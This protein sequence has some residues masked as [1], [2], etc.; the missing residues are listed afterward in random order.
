MVP[1]KSLPEPDHSDLKSP[2]GVLFLLPLPAPTPGL[3]TLHHAF[4]TGIFPLPRAQKLVLEDKKNLT[5]FIYKA[6]IYTNYI[7]RYTMKYNF[8]G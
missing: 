1:Y 4:S 6:C 8:I 7:N 2:L 3:K 5:H